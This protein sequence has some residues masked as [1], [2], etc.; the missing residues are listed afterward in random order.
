MTL[1]DSI[2]WLWGVMAVVAGVRSRGPGG[3]TWWAPG[4]GALL[5]A[6]LHLFGW[7]K[8]IYLAGKRLVAWTGFYDERLWFKFAIGLV[9]FPLVVWLCWRAFGWARRLSPLQRL[10]LAA[11]AVDL[12]YITSRTLSVD[13]WMPDAIGGEPG[14]SRLG[15]TLAAIGVVAVACAR[16]RD[17]GHDAAARG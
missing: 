13:G 14:K 3:R 11:V 17:G 1:A 6:S 12:L 8:P 7:N 5:Q 4:A 10:A 15:A 9:F 2:A 16:P